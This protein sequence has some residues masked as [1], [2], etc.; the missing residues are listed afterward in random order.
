[1]VI[2]RFNRALAVCFFL[3]LITIVVVVV[4][5]F[6]YLVFRDASWDLLGAG[7][8]VILGV[9]SLALSVAMIRVVFRDSRAIWIQNEALHFYSST[10]DDALFFL[11]S[12]ETVL[13][14]SIV[15]LSSVKAEFPGAVERQG[16]YVNLKSGK[17]HKM[18]T[19]VLTERR[20]V[21]MARLRQALGFE[22]AKS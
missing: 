21:V 10:F 9:V 12:K 16:I 11:V 6:A 2:A 17:S 5:G 15:G 19:S 1:M 8:P 18:L 7:W 14:D 3:L 13:L 20:P 4:G 22:E